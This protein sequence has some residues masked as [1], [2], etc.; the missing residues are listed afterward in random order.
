MF[1]FQFARPAVS[2]WVGA[3]GTDGFR[4]RV[5]W[6]CRLKY[7]MSSLNRLPL[8]FTAM[9]ALT[10]CGTAQYGQD[11]PYYRYP[12]GVTLVL[13]QPLDIPPDAATVRLQYGGTVA[14]NSVQEQ[15]PFCVFELTTVRPIAQRVEPDTFEVVD[16]N[17]SISTIAKAPEPASPFLRVGMGGMDSKPSFL[18]YK[19]AFRLRSARQPHVMAMTCMSNQLLSGDPA[20]RYLTLAEIR[21]ALGSLF[22]V[23][24][25]AS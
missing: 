9:L 21:Q 2:W 6:T 1:A 19:T 10:A 22:S 8:Y 23:V 24:I 18:Y 3:G 15:D 12:P 7:F 25:P 14:R 16:V 4:S 17:Y 11:S 5:R 20:F 13:N